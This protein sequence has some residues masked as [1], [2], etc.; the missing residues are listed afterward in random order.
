MGMGLELR[1]QNATWVFETDSVR[2]RYG[3]GIRVPALLKELR[4]VV[5]PD[6]ALAGADVSVGSRRT[7]LQMRLRQGACPLLEAAAGQLGEGSDPYRIV[8]RADQAD[9]AEHYAEDLRT[10]A[11]LNP[12]ADR[13]AERF[14]L[15]G[16]RPPRH[17][18]AY[19]GN[20][21]F[22]GKTVAFRWMW[23]GAS[24]AKWRAGDQVFPVSDI[25]DVEWAAP[26]VLS[27]HLRVRLRG[28]GDDVRR[29]DPDQDPR[30]LTFGVGYGLTHESLTFAAA[31]LYAIA[32]HRTVVRAAPEAVPAVSA[33][34]ALPPPPPPPSLSGSG[35][36]PSVDE[37]IATIRKLGELRDAG[38]LSEDEFQRKKAELLARL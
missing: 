22:D 30:A 26:G 23:S 20:G 4:E 13:P 28:D 14:L 6:V 11:A 24:S 29:L 35:G 17:V 1:G 37:V 19:D 5:V 3:T 33:P 27:G 2:V 8:L 10:R 34:A 12:A 15:P 21:V 25:V 36:G 18:K 16:P 38:L 7:I 9:L 32:D 31:V